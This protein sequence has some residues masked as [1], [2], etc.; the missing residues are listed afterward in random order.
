MKTINKR[1]K[2][3]MTTPN[4]NIRTKSEETSKNLEKMNPFG[5]S[6]HKRNYHFTIDDEIKFTEPQKLKIIHSRINAV[7]SFSV[8]KSKKPHH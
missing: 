3:Y 4:N 5:S 8:P 7:Q 2:S 1:N 6:K